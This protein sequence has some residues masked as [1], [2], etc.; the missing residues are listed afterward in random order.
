MGAITIDAP[1]EGVPLPPGTFANATVTVDKA[2]LDDGVY[3]SDNL[4][5]NTDLFGFEVI[6]MAVV[7]QRPAR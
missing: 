7:V 1:L 5:L 6:P 3:D 4:V 2:L